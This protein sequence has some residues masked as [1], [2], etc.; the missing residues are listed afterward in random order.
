MTF[1][2]V[3]GAEPA[4]RLTQHLGR[5]GPRLRTARSPHFRRRWEVSA[6]VGVE[7]KVGDRGLSG[8]A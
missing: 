7:P 2:A 5:A 6:V 4:D 3:H 8:A 1:Q